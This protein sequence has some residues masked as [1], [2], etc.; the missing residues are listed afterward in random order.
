MPKLSTAHAL[1]NMVHEWSK[2]TNGSGTEMRVTILDYKKAF[3]LIDHFLLI[4][5]LLQYGIN[6]RIIHWICDFLRNRLQ[7]VKLADD[8]YSE[9]KTVQGTKLG[10]WLFI[11][12]INDLNIPS[13]NGIF[14]SDVDDTIIDEVIEKGSSLMQSHTNEI[15]EWS[16]LNKFQLHPKKCKELRISLKC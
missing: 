15:S 6:P 3:D 10:A 2:A 7:R 13:A 9:W 8:C 12:M 1:L 14:K 11:V 4:S 5:K 16:K